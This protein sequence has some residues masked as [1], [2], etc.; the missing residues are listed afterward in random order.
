MYPNV[1][2][3]FSRDEKEFMIQ[4]SKQSLKTKVPEME[5]KQYLLYFKELQAE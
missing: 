5:Q 3:F 1:M 2:Y 4:E